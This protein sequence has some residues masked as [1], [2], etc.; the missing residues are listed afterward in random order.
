MFKVKYF[1]IIV[2]VITLVTMFSATLNYTSADSFVGDACSGLT[3]VTKAGC[4]KG[5]DTIKSIAHNVVNILSIVVGVIS[6]IMLLV[7][8][9]KFVTAGGDSNS[10]QSAR[11]TLIYALIGVFIAVLAQVLVREVLNTATSIQNNSYL[12]TSSVIK[13]DV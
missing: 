11:N 5:G 8:G 2:A 10:V 9:I 13:N 1:K 6:V 4:S 12:N 3:T 7:A